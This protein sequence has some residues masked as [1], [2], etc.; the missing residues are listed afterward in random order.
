MPTE[1]PTYSIRPGFKDKFKPAAVKAL[2]TTV[3]Q[4]RLQDKT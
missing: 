3:L 4:E 1:E 2:I